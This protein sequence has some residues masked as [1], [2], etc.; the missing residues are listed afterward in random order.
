MAKENKNKAGENKDR[1]T[2]SAGQVKFIPPEENKQKAEQK[3]DK[4]EK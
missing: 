3:A 2:W 4:K 1:F